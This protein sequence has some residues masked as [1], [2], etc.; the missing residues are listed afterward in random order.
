M[1]RKE[2]LTVWENGCNIIDT[3]T[4][5]LKVKPEELRKDYY[6]KDKLTTPELVKFI[7]QE[8]HRGTEGLKYIEGGTISP[9]RYTGSRFI[10]NDDWCCY[11]Q[12]ENP[13][14]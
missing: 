4:I 13:G 6:L 3:L 14:R 11:C 8:E 5:N 9:F 2:M 7:E 1:L 12:P 10:I